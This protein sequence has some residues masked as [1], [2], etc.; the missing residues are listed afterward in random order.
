MK[1]PTLINSSSKINGELTFSTDVRIDGEVFG[2]VESDKS[3]IIG[4][5]GY[6]KGFL[7][8]KDL[9]VFGR[10]EGNIIVSGLTILHEKASV[11]GNL[12][13][14]TFEVKDGATI[15]A[16]VV[17]YDELEAID[18]AQ[19]YLA[20]EMI[21]SEPSRR[22]APASSHVMISF[23]DAIDSVKEDKLT[24]ASKDQPLPESL[25][26]DSGDVLS[27][28]IESKINPEDLILYKHNPELGY[29]EE[30][31]DLPSPSVHSFEL[32]ESYSSDKVLIEELNPVMADQNE[33]LS[34][35]N[36]SEST[37]N[38]IFS[39]SKLEDDEIAS[40]NQEPSEENEKFT[41]L[42]IGTELFDDQS[43]K[44][45]ET[46]VS[47]VGTKSESNQN[48]TLEFDFEDNSVDNDEI[49]LS[50][51]INPV[52][53][54]ECLGEPVMEES[55]M[56]K[57]GK[58]KPI[59][60]IIPQTTRKNKGGYSIS[61]FEELRNLLIPVKYQQMKLIEKKNDQEKYN[62]KK[63]SENDNGIRAKE[64]EKSELFLN[65]AIRQLP[66]DDYSSLF[67]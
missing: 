58:K 3:V 49:S 4:A 30:N 62:L 20:E 38:S 66:D 15:T 29:P 13:T 28:I 5:E 19:I 67:N 27:K 22:Q 37:V 39:D 6:V 47:E 10:F 45:L 50:P 33:T 65:N 51:P 23:D 12:Y 34:L 55:T 18:E 21:K 9:V 60:S 52:S 54:A 14:K 44:P 2:K 63:V 42:P 48:Q 32:F 8:A 56:L 11:F 57:K 40:S 46:S 25:L 24:I 41:L 61:G 16:R 26:N 1:I 64:S 17:M 7:R 31:S 35:L 53:I 36:I 59:S 43:F